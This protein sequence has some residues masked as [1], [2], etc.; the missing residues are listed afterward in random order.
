M[1]FGVGGICMD[2]VFSSVFDSD[3]D[4]I[5]DKLDYCPDTSQG[6]TVNAKGCSDTQL[7]ETG[8]C[9]ED[10]ETPIVD[11]IP[12]FGLLLSI[13]A[14]LGAAIIATR[15]DEPDPAKMGEDDGTP[16]TIDGWHVS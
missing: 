9:E 14:A 7:S 8:S 13:A 5:I 6:E 11:G 2:G 16:P 3:G 1:D 15:R 4:G 10:C 12:G